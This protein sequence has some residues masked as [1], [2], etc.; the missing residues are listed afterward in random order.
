MPEDMELIL[1]S[2][3]LETY[4]VI[5]DI[6]FYEKLFME[7]ESIEALNS[8]AP[9]AFSIIQRSVGND[10][11]ASI[12]RLLDPEKSCGNENLTLM[13]LCSIFGNEKDWPEVA[14]ELKK[15]GGDFKDY[16]NK[17]LSHNDLSRV[18]SPSDTETLVFPWSAV[19]SF[20]EKAPV[21]IN[22]VKRQIS[23]SEAF[24]SIKPKPADALLRAINA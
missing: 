14:H 20:S 10:I 9:K 19:L 8:A 12:F 15:I 4:R 23:N 1:D 3:Y 22:I 21:L 13:K 11:M 7:S 24:F 16:R 18:V 6:K 17:I 2:I 5:K